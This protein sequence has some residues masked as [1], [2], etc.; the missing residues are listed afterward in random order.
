MAKLGPNLC[1][2]PSIVRL[3]TTTPHIFLMDLSLFTPLWASQ[4]PQSIIC[5]LT[6]LYDLELWVLSEQLKDP[7]KP[8]RLIATLRAWW[9][10]DVPEPQVFHPNTH[11][12]TTYHWQRPRSWL[13]ASL[14]QTGCWARYRFHRH[15]GSWGESGMVSTMS[16]ASPAH[17]PPV[18]FQGFQ[19]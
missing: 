1:S 5:S 7:E 9:L 8:C 15:F 17:A 18:L 3:I 14:C 19:I 4:D 13:V 11:I 16:Q 6:W 10:W 12:G 2:P